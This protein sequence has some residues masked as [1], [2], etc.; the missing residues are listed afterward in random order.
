MADAPPPPPAFRPPSPTPLSIKATSYR[1]ARQNELDAVRSK[2]VA[3]IFY[4]HFT[5]ATEKIRAE[6][7]AAE[8][9]LNDIIAR[10]AGLKANPKIFDKDGLTLTQLDALHMELQKKSK[11]VQRKERETIEL[12]RRYVSQY[13]GNEAAA[14]K[15]LSKHGSPSPVVNANL[16][17][18]IT[19]LGSTMPVLHENRDYD[20]I[21]Q[22]DLE[23]ARA[24][25]KKTCDGVGSVTAQRLEDG[26][27]YD[28]TRVPTPPR[29]VGKLNRKENAVQ[30]PPLLDITRDLSSN[31]GIDS[32]GVVACSGS[33]S[34]TTL[35]P[36]DKKAATKNVLLEFPPLSPSNSFGN[37]SGLEG[38]FLGGVMIG[39]DDDSGDADSAMSGLTSMDGA[40]IA[41]AEFT[42]TEF[43]R[44]E[45]ENIRQML[46]GNIGQSDYDDDELSDIQ[47]VK[48]TT[49]L[50]SQKASYAAKNAEQLAKEMEE[51]TAW[52]DNPSLLDNDS[53]EEK[54]V[55]TNT[56]SAP[57][58]VAYYCDD[59]KKPYYYNTVTTQTCWTEPRD[60]VI[61]KSALKKSEI[62]NDHKCDDED[63]VIVKDYTKYDTA[64]VKDYT[65]S[66]PKDN[67]P[68]NRSMEEN[69]A[70]IDQ[71]RPDSDAISVASGH[72]SRTS[73][74]SKSMAYKR[75]R[76]LKRRRRNRVIIFVFTVCSM[77][78]TV[79]YKSRERWMPMLG[80]QTV[81]QREATI[82]T[83]RANKERL[84]KEEEEGKK[85]A[86]SEAKK[87]AELEA[88]KKA[89]LEAKK[90]AEL[91]AKKKAESDGK[92]K[93]EEKRIEAEQAARKKA[94][95]AKLAAKK[96]T[97]E[98]ELV[99]KKKT[100]E[101]RIKAELAAQKKVEEERIKAEKLEK[102][103]KEKAEKTAK[104]K[105]EEERKATE[106]AEKKAIEERK[107][108]EL[109]EKKAVEERKTAE[110][111][112]KK[113]AKAEEERIKTELATKKK[114]EE[115]RIAAEL[116][117]ARKVEEKRKLAE[118]EAAK[119]A[120]E[121]KR[122]LAEIKAEK[123][124]KLAKV[125]A[126]EKRKQQEEAARKQL[127][128]KIREDERR[129]V[130]AEFRLK[131]QEQEQNA[132][133]LQ[134][135]SEKKVNCRLPFAR[136]FMKPC[137]AKAEKAKAESK[138][139]RKPLFDLSALIDSMMQ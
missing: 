58:W 54:S 82:V 52:I 55:Q 132:S 49:T 7:E 128:D 65:K 25:E 46:T 76:A 117:A 61:D 28:S 124:R 66:A 133:S 53:D 21:R 108:T 130:E 64:A 101:K 126:E 96:K 34:S 75:K 137:K 29:G 74:A 134:V 121:E 86:E 135:I 111:A 79:V 45:T 16:S 40:T 139:K 62:P 116:E 71:F 123:E 14:R 109:A 39:N 60:T 17:S 103:A 13:G 81:R 112:E 88:K 72:M 102:A 6:R 91:E 127:E 59:H 44:E 129:K 50:E 22:T 23:T 113:A 136:F 32:P 70:Q 125:K 77:F 122:K 85:K 110:L 5:D 84:L 119:K 95:E 1:S 27:F 120:E 24:K 11:T 42:L 107:A 92:K 18:S 10:K 4:R 15:A 47:T 26:S 69:L 93:I 98:A 2:G 94:E 30:S 68:Q 138:K 106:L 83:E 57:E 48:T 73:R 41:I 35:Q 63:T 12:H 87:H 115:E 114:A 31:I 3:K 78:G 105:A 38:S 104:K 9:A 51:A 37:I 100:E 97:E 90:K 56:K 19:G 33:G 43:L 67:Q 99:A 118:L 8:F 89:E 20:I 36:Q 80:M 131:E